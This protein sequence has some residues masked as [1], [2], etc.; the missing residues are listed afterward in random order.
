VKFCESY[1]AAVEFPHPSSSPT[2]NSPAPGAAVPPGA[3]GPAK[4]SQPLKII[5]AI[6]IALVVL[7]GAGYFF[8]LPK[9]SGGAS[10][11]AF[12]GLSGTVATP[13]PTP[14]VTVP[15]PVT[16]ATTIAPT[17]T[18]D[19]FPN[20]LLLKDGF[21]FGSEKVASEATVYDDGIPHLVWGFSMT[22]KGKDIPEYLDH[23]MDVDAESGAILLAM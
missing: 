12:P 16:V 19:P 21:P 9:L 11:L 2:V 15:A 3:P 14:F 1:G 6:V 8:V 20:A 23:M 13:T 4:R 17:P 10:P 22:V 18:P 5:A 7:V